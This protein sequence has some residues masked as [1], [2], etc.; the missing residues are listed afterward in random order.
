MASYI[1]SLV[2]SL[3]AAGHRTVLRCA[4]SSTTGA[5]LLAMI[6]RYARVLDGQGLRRGDLVALLAPNRPEALAVR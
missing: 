6:S 2:T 4:G 1:D 3:G 5:E